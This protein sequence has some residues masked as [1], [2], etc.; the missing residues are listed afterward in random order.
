MNK[1]SKG[2]VAVF[3][4]LMRLAGDAGYEFFFI[5][6]LL[7]MGNKDLNPSSPCKGD[8]SMSLRYKP[9]NDTGYEL[10][11][12]ISH[13]LYVFAPVLGGIRK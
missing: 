6:Q 3:I 10:D 12:L 13:F 4:I 8:Q 7:Q 5:I 9:L 2:K 1:L 11:D